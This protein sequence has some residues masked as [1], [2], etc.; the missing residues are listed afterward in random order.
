[1]E[2]RSYYQQCIYGARFPLSV[3]GGVA[4]YT[5]EILPNTINPA[6]GSISSTGIYSA[7]NKNGVDTIQV[8]DDLGETATFKV[9]VG[10]YMHVVGEIIRKYCGFSEDQV[11]VY[12]QKLT[13][14]KDTRVYVAVREVY[15]NVLGKSSSTY[16]AGTVLENEQ[17]LLLSSNIDVSV[18]T[19]SLQEFEKRHLVNMALSSVYSERQQELNGFK[20][21]LNPTNIANAYNVDGSKIPYYSNLNYNVQYK[22]TRVE[23]VPYFNGIEIDGVITNA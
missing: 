9:A 13:I 10:S 19:S 21:G 20:I 11:I 8:T 3:V 22:I 12:N 2:L 23:D 15:T 4:P 5:F 16:S 6:G 14:P 7:S 18:Y 17:T 1:M